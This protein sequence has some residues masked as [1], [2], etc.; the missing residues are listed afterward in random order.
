MQTESN[1]INTITRWA[2]R[3]SFSYGIAFFS[4]YLVYCILDSLIN[5]GRTFAEDIT[6]WKTLYIHP[7]ALGT[8]LG[9]GLLGI[10]FSK[11]HAFVCAI[12]GF[13]G[14]SLVSL[15][16][17]FFV[18]VPPTSPHTNL[19]V[20]VAPFIQ[21]GLTGIVIGIAIGVVLRGWKNAAWYAIAGAFGFIIGWFFN[22][23][24]AE[25]IL[26]RSP[27]HG[28]IARVVVGDPWYYLYWLV[29]A[30]LYGC[31]FGLCLGAVTFFTK[32]KN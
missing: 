21:Q 2:L 19:D 4:I 1:K 25:I 14:Y 3:G 29:P 10:F 7:T 8:G 16:W 22:R 23:I 13:I 26:I 5:S 11:R 20:V 31:I 24:L 27:Y 17:H 15:L 12:A 9:A 28:H 30:I 18:A 32:E 6:I